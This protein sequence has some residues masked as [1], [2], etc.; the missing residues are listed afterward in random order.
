M[1]KCKC[2]KV[3]IRVVKDK[4]GCGYDFID[5]L[6]LIDPED[7]PY[8]FDRFFSRRKGGSGLG[9]SY[10]KDAMKGQKGTI[11]ASSKKGVH[12]TFHVRFRPLAATPPSADTGSAGSNQKRTGG[13]NDEE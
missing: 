10:N 3:M 13:K 4:E 7:M 12:T 11:S 1:K 5:T 2:G 9:L 8:L 6:G